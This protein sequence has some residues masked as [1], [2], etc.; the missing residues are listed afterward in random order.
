MRELYELKEKVMHELKDYSNKEL[1]AGSLDI[2]KNLTKTA[3]D[4]S[5]LI[6]W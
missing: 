5:F 6:V 3:M 1:T 4:T 2:I